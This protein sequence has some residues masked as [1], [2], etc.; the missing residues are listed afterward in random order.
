MTN[1]SLSVE[2]LLLGG[3]GSNGNDGAGGGGG[4]NGGGAP[5]LAPNFQGNDNP[6]RFS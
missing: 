4:Y 6:L 1:R 5:T 3:G 2:M